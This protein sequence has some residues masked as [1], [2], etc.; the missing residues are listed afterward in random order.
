MSIQGNSLVDVCFWVPEIFEVH[1]GFHI[2]MLAHFTV[3]LQKCLYVHVRAHDRAHIRSSRPSPMYAYSQPTQLRNLGFNSVEKRRYANTV[4]IFVEIA[5][6][7]YSPL[8]GCFMLR[9]H[10]F[11]LTPTY[12]IW[13]YQLPITQCVSCVKERVQRL[14]QSCDY[15]GSPARDNSDSKF[16]FKRLHC[17]HSIASPPLTLPSKLW[18]ESSEPDVDVCPAVHC[19]K[20]DRLPGRA[21]ARVSTTYLLSVLQEWAGFSRRASAGS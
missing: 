20:V 8:L 19:F 17:E 4:W 9:E 10:D 15:A 1:W 12:H 11:K 3:Y 21:L 13:Q 7:G 14:H 2:G 6:P 16:R 5:L 18:S